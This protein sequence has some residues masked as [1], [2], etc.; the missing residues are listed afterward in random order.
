MTDNKCFFFIFYKEL[1]SPLRQPEFK[2]NIVLI[3]LNTEILLHTPSINFAPIYLRQPTSDI[4][5][6]FIYLFINYNTI[7]NYILTIYELSNLDH[8]LG[9]VSQTR[10]SGVNRTHDPH[11]NILAYYPLDYQGTRDQSC[12]EFKKGT[13]TLHIVIRVES[14]EASSPTTQT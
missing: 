12:S 8:T 1:S 5:Y 4:K 10:V 3:A 11:A 9:V 7:T 2:E 14:T 13:L 6:L